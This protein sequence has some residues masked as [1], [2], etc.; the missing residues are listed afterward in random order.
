MAAYTKMAKWSEN[1]FLNIHDHYDKID[2]EDIAPLNKKL[3]GSR[4]IK[5]MTR[6]AQMCPKALK[7]CG[8]RQLNI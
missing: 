7:A 6:R 8:I 5:L 2:K 3:P 4:F 1:F